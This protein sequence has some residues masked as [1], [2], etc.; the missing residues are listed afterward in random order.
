[1]DAGVRRGISRAA[2]DWQFTAGITFGFS[3][4]YSG[5]P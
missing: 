5:K 1:V 2:P 4:P 3:L